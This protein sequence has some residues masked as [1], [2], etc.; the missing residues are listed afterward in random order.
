[1]ASLNG[2]E[3]EQALEDGEGQGS[4]A[5]YSPWGHRV[6]HDLATEQQQCSAM[7]SRVKLQENKTFQQ[8]VKLCWIFLTKMSKVHR[9]QIHTNIEI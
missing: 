1:M 5:C 2:H 9:L 7:L 4:L 3:F 8:P 6:R